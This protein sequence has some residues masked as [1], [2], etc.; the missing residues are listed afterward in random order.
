MEILGNFFNKSLIEGLSNNNYKNILDDNINKLSVYKEKARNICSLNSKE[1][2]ENL[3]NNIEID[4]DNIKNINKQIGECLENINSSNCK[5]VNEDDYKK[6]INREVTSQGI[7]MYSMSDAN[8]MINENLL[9]LG[10]IS[11]MIYLMVNHSSVK[12]QNIT[13]RLNTSG[14]YLKNLTSTTLST[15]DYLHSMVKNINNNKL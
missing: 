9:L 4:R 3:K 7:M 8:K 10:L 13:N 6:N 15:T 11:L 14:R 5:F 2:L 1:D 12:K